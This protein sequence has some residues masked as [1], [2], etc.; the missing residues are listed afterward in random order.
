MAT[1]HSKHGPG[2]KD[3]TRRKDGILSSWFLTFSF[4]LTFCK[5]SEVSYRLFIVNQ[6]IFRQS[7]PK[8][9]SLYGST[10][11]YCKVLPRE[12]STCKDLANRLR[13]I[14]TQK[15]HGAHQFLVHLKPAP[16]G[17]A[18]G[19]YTA[20]VSEVSLCLHPSQ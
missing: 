13:L 5:M 12:S 9:F 18:Y 15:V 14:C 17:A 20:D 11:S 2:V 16:G 8:F 1:C 7:C 3:Q 4:S 19:F 10:T 6:P